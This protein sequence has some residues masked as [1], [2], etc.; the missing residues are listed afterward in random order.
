M[1]SPHFLTRCD[2]IYLEY[3]YLVE[4]KGKAVTMTLLTGEFLAQI[5]AEN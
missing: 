4:P 1:K 2:M 3:W 5:E